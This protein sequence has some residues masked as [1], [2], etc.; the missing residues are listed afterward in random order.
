[1]C[2]T[3]SAANLIGENHGLDVIYRLIPQYTTKHLNTIKYVYP[4]FLHVTLATH[5][6]ISLGDIWQSLDNTDWQRY[7]TKLPLSQHPQA[8]LQALASKYQLMCK[9]LIVDG[10]YGPWLTH[11]MK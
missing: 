6:P 10:G 9:L 8:S 5:I 3:V 1:M 11:N 4:G 7:S 2:S